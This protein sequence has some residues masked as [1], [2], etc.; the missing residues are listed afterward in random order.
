MSPSESLVS[1]CVPTYNRAAALCQELQDIGRQDYPRL[2]ILISDNGSDDATPEV[3]GEAAAK[4]ARIRY[5]RHPANIG[6]YRNHNFCIDATHG[7]LL[8]FFHDHDEHDPTMISHYVAFLQRHP[9]VGAVCSNWELIDEAGRCLGV[10]DQP[11]PSVTSGLDFISRTIRSG[12]C[13]LGI[14][15]TMVRRSALGS[16]RF[17][18]EG[19]I[20]FGDFPVWL[21]LAERASIGHLHQRLW[22]CRQIRQS[23]SACTIETMTRDYEEALTGYCD[24]HLAR[25]PSHRAL[26]ERWKRAIRRYLFWA[27]AFEVGLYYRTREPHAT[28][29]RPNSTLFELLDYRLDPAAL[30][31]AVDRLWLYRTGGLETMTCLAMALLIRVRM[32]ALFTWATHHVAAFRR[33]LRLQ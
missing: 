32:P 16:I 20:G 3:C 14:P 18:T 21:E 30:Q 15:G 9:E 24:G 33:L 2:E 4:D 10:R 17:D 31:R 28:G 26:V 8:C 27:L 5:V 1:I 13:S 29:P 23:Q 19:P 11:V 25:W 12:R 7:E 6:L 22:R